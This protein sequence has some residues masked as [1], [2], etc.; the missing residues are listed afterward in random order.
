MET[1]KNVELEHLTDEDL[2]LKELAKMQ[3][4]AP[5]DTF[6][7]LQKRV[8]IAQVGKDLVEKQAF[9]FWSVIDAFL[10]MLFV[11]NKRSTEEEKKNIGDNK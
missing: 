8:Q 4:S 9:A 5:E 3:V 11:Q 7:R 10:R 6:K 2:D 1:E